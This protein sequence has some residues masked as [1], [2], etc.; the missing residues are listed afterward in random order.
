MWGDWPRPLLFSAD[1]NLAPN[2]DPSKPWKDALVQPRWEMRTRD[3]TVPLEPMEHK[4]GDLP[5][6]CELRDASGQLRERWDEDSFQKRVQARL[7]EKAALSG[8]FF[9][10]NI[11]N[12]ETKTVRVELR[13]RRLEWVSQ[14]CARTL[15]RASR[16][17]F[18]CC[19]RCTE[20]VSGSG[21]QEE[22]G[23]W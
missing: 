12:W 22:G 21:D 1:R 5:P 7:F 20:E 19:E 8:G 18:M 11:A 16:P 14:R 9:P 6:G 13:S 17:M 10:K 15:G 2:F 3:S 23:E 4:A